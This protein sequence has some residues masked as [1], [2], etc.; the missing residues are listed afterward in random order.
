MKWE[1]LILIVESI[2]ISIFKI[3]FQLMTVEK[4]LTLIVESVYPVDRGT[5]VVAT[6]HEEVLGVLQQSISY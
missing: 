5:L 1:L 3:N 4:L 6:Q 2:Y